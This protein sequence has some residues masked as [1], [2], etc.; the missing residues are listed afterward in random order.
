MFADEILPLQID[1]GRAPWLAEIA[2]S[3]L[4][5]SHNAVHS[6]VFECGAKN[7]Q[8]FSHASTSPLLGRKNI[9]NKLS[10]S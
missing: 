1:A 2:M 4:H 5:D 9:Y 8:L 3:M 10:Y 6:P 7:C